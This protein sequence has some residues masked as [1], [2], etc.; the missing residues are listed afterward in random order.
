[1]SESGVRLSGGRVL[2]VDD[3]PL[4]RAIV[5]KRLR[6][7][8]YRVEEAA[9][10]ASALALLEKDA[11][12]DVVLTDLRMPSVDGF[13]VLD[14]VQ[15]RQLET[16]VIVLTGTYAEDPAA[17]IRAFRLGAT[18]FLAKAAH[19]QAVAAVEQAV[20]RKRQREE[21]RDAEER[22]RKSRDQLNAAQHLAHVGSWEWRPPDSFAWSDE[23][24]R[25]HGLSPQEPTPCGEL[26]WRHLHPG[27]RERVRRIGEKAMEDGLPFSYHYRIVR[28]DASVRVLL[29]RG[30]AVFGGAGRPIALMGADQDVTELRQ[31][32]QAL[33]LQ[34]EQLGAVAE[35]MM[36]F[37]S[38]GDVAAATERLLRS[39]AQQTESEYGFVAVAD[40]GRRLR[41]ISEY[42]SPL[43]LPNAALDVG[44][45][46]LRLLDGGGTVVVNQQP[47][48]GWLAARL[49]GRQP[50]NL[51]G[52]PLARGA[53]VVGAIVM[54]NRAADYTLVEKG[55][56]EL[57]SQAIGVIVDSHLR[58][59][60]EAVLEQ[61]LRQAQKMEAVG[62]LAGGIAHD[63]NNVLTAIMGYGQSIQRELDGDESRIR[64]RLDGIMR[65]ADRAA[66]LTKQLLAFS[67]NQI[68]EPRTLDLNHVVDDVGDMLRRLIGEDVEL[69]IRLDRGLGCVKADPSQIQQVLMNLAANA[70]DS[71]PDGGRLEIETKNVPL[72]P[73]FVAEHVGSRAGE[74]VL[75]A[76]RDNGVG[77]DA[78]TQSHIFEPFFTTK[79]S[80]SGTG[81]GLATVYGIVKQAG[82]YIDVQSAPLNGA[83]FNVYFPRYEGT[84]ELRADG[85]REPDAAHGSA[86]IM[87]VEDEDMLREVLAETLESSGYSIL[88][89]KNGEQ[90]LETARAH[91]GP[92]QLLLT[93]VVMPHMNGHELGR[94][95]RE[96]RPRTPVLYMTG[97]T[98]SALVSQMLRERATILQKPFTPEALLHEVRSALLARA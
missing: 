55:P 96:L 82:G 28:D 69:V 37:L 89:A 57:L 60:R 86:T 91:A 35:A 27:D 29:S 67:R 19:D 49:G 59:Q 78:E 15:K 77:M 75:L 38:Q 46:L 1:M 88:A 3:S 72:D 22:Y 6:A 39:A 70:R 64:P 52:V 44:E 97:Y 54:A 5:A 50:Q 7:A 20:Q 47:A 65:A 90:A 14:A 61:Q 24:Y 25:I 84:P 42:G 56:L 48:C 21:L 10:G 81:L 13:G 95:L 80:G 73:E 93:D 23:L 68:V 34:T 83:T 43:S 53:D 58:R 87:L 2:V 8:G 71:M 12:F 33:E 41:L 18:D 17:A 11:D 79:R 63:F 4:A 51:L 94:R 45:P 40:E 98:E 85:R 76:V 9:D 62:R 36:T 32:E 30:E 74:H 26:F 16:E 31:A 92:I 66:A